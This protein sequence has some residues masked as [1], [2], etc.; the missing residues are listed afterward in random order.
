M[1]NSNFVTKIF[2]INDYR[3]FRYFDRR[4]RKFKLCKLEFGTNIF[5]VKF[6]KGRNE[7]VKFRLN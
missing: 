1:Q 6:E 4:N 7:K 3:N 5:W 2:Y